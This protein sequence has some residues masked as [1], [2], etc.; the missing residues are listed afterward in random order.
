M[1]ICSADLLAII[2]SENSKNNKKYRELQD[3]LSTHWFISSREL[4]EAKEVIRSEYPDSDFQFK[5]AWQG[6]ETKVITV[7]QVLDIL[8]KK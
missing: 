7:S 6:N 2:F 3:I 4:E 8:S 1:G 5:V